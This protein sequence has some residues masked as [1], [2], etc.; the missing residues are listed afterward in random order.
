M[1]IRQSAMGFMFLAV[2]R[3]MGRL[4]R[5][6][7]PDFTTYETENTVK[8]ANPRLAILHKLI[9]LGAFLYACDNILGDRGYL[10]YS[11][12]VAAF[13]VRLHDISPPSTTYKS[14]REAPYCNSRVCHFG[15]ACH[16]DE[17]GCS[18][19]TE[20][21]Q[22]KCRLLCD[23]SQ[24][25][26]SECKCKATKDGTQRCVRQVCAVAECKFFDALEIQYGMMDSA[27]FITTRVDEIAEDFN[28]VRLRSNRPECADTANTQLLKSDQSQSWT[29]HCCEVV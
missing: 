20:A 26:S 14:F 23:P 29:K 6:Q 9:C 1:N 19:Y 28:C 2:G 21:G 7:L 18:C 13:Q 12:P 16:E 22:T 27:I 15:A 24:L 3:W 11:D 5:N 8:L 10:A 4:A 17:P 25:S